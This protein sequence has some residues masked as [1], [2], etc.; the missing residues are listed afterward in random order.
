MT[1]PVTRKKCAR[2]CKFS[3]ESLDMNCELQAQAQAQSPT[4]AGRYY[5][6]PSARLGAIEGAVNSLQGNA[7]KRSRRIELRRITGVL[8]ALKLIPQSEIVVGLG[9]GTLST[10]ES[11]LFILC[12]TPHH[13]AGDIPNQGGSYA[14]ERK[15]DE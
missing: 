8:K 3:F 13:V 9:F 14:S 2:D 11:G 4:A 1:C 10:G 7:L 15:R 12:N 5:F 6:I